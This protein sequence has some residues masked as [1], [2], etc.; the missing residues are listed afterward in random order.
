MNA[1]LETYHH[2]GNKIEKY[3]R[4]STFPLAVKVIKALKGLPWILN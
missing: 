4:P 2:I 3:I 1:N